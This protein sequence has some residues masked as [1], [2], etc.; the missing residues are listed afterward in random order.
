M[1]AIQWITQVFQQMCLVLMKVMTIL[2]IFFFWQDSDKWISNTTVFKSSFL[3]N[4]GSNV[5][6]HC[7]YR[8][9]CDNVTKLKRETCHFKHKRTRDSAISDIKVTLKHTTFVL[10]MHFFPNLSDFRLITAIENNALNICD[11]LHNH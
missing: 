1:R 7:I 4:Y 3:Q 5:T 9:T 10:N 2:F 6:L 11:Q 8:G